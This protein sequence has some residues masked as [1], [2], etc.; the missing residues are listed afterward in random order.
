MANHPEYRMGTTVL[1]DFSSKARSI[2]CLYPIGEP[3]ILIQKSTCEMALFLIRQYNAPRGL[4]VF[5][6]HVLLD[7]IIKIRHLNDCSTKDVGTA[8]KELCV[9]L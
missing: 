7:L 8:N 2:M 4:G 1:D 6:H 9:L 5:K 3:H